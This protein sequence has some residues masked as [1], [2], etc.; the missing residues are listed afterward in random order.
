M[1]PEI[2]LVRHGDVEY[3]YG[4]GGKR[5]VYG[6]DTP[7]SA[8]GRSQIETAANIFLQEKIKIDVIYTSPMLR[9]V[10]TANILSD[11]LGQK[12]IVV[13]EDL[14]EVYAPGWIGAPMDELGIVNGDI[15]AN[16]KTPD[17]ETLE[18][19]KGRMGRF[20]ERIKRFEEGRGVIIVG[21]REPLRVLNHILSHA[22]ASS[23]QSYQEFIEDEF[24][25]RGAVW[26]LGWDA[27]GFVNKR[28]LVNGAN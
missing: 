6:P 22:N 28:E 4:A 1:S 2:Y 16:L 10:E 18:S 9:T 8:S 12:S 17:Q 3:E 25:E 7:L 20:F 26:K 14:Q 13:N 23:M 15:F 11:K 21:H 19:V 5:L 24:I 27:F